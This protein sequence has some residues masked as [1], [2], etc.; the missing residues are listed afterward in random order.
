MMEKSGSISY[1]NNIGGFNVSLAYKD[2]QFDN[3]DIPNGAIIHMEDEHHD[4]EE[5]HDEDEHHDDEEHHD[6][7]E[8]HDEENLGY[9]ENSDFES[10]HLK[11]LEFQRQA[12]GGILAFHIETLKVFL[13]FLSMVTAMATKVTEC[14]TKTSIMTKT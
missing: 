5:H 6:E 2:S 12:T 7:D 1:Q 3:Y 13:E 14:T 4:E 9:L 11:D 8:H 10:N